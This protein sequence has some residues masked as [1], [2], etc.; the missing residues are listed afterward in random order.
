MFHHDHPRRGME[1]LCPAV[2][3]ESLPYREHVV[4]AGWREI[5]DRGE[6]REESF[7]GGRAARDSSP[8]KEI[9]GDEALVGVPRPASG[10]ITP[11]RRM[12]IELAARDLGWRR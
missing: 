4:E 12:T 11:I 3:P 2:K 9:L 5:V 7:V 8:L 6:P 10:D 1:T